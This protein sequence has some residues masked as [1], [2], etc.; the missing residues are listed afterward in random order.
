MVYKRVPRPSTS[1]YRKT[2]KHVTNEDRP[3]V[4]Q[5]YNDFADV[6]KSHNDFIY[7]NKYNF[8][9]PDFEEFEYDIIQ[10]DSDRAS[11]SDNVSPKAIA[12]QTRNNKILASSSEFCK[13]ATGEQQL[14][15][16][17][18]NT[19]STSLSRQNSLKNASKYA[20]NGTPLKNKISYQNTNNQT[21]SFQTQSFEQSP[22]VPYLKLPSKNQSDITNNSNLSSCQ[23]MNAPRAGK[24]Q[25]LEPDFNV[26]TLDS[27]KS[28]LSQSE[29]IKV[30]E[31]VRYS[32]PPFRSYY[33]YGTSNGLA[34]TNS[35]INK[36]TFNLAAAA[37]GNGNNVHESVK[38]HS[39][40]VPSKN[41]N[42]SHNFMKQ[43]NSSAEF[44]KNTLGFRRPKSAQLQYPSNKARM[45]PPFDRWQTS[46][47]VHFPKQGR[48]VV[49][50]KVKTY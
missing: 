26:T 7:T 24:V 46:H 38:I 35:G 49:D 32:K 42:I 23:I 22:K 18:T 20:V 37:N 43:S 1:T 10:L 30:V 27:V 36:K 12:T 41:L 28:A 50:A 5:D 9:A 17:V 11:V 4:V 33:G 13:F 3:E 2:F 19:S 29:P 40:K 39:N 21:Q 6:R 16:T 44:H 48:K 25:T 14:L 15:N 34:G 31:N 47:K 45:D 8:W